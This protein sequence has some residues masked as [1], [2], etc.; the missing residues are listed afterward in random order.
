MGY[1]E[2]TIKMRSEDPVINRILATLRAANVSGPEYHAI[3]AI[4]ITGVDDR[5]VREDFPVPSPSWE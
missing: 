3:R 2:N 5:F 4:L 1:R